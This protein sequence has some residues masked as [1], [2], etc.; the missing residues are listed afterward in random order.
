MLKRKERW[1]HLVI[2]FFHSV[3][4]MRQDYRHFCWSIVKHCTLD[5][6]II[7]FIVLLKTYYL[8]RKKKTERNLSTYPCINK[9]IKLFK[10]YIKEKYFSN[11]FSFKSW[12]HF[13][14]SQE[15]NLRTLPFF[16]ISQCLLKIFSTVLKI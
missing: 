15:E 1:R 4:V 11:I 14:Q 8:R 5:L 13:M 9:H 12:C 10:T 6:K 2:V 16:I 3:S 7:K